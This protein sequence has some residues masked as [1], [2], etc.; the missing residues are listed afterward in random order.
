MRNRVAV[1]SLGILL[2]LSLA[3]CSGQ[4]SSITSESTAGP[5]KPL[6]PTPAL[7]ATH[8][9]SPLASPLDSPLPTPSGSRPFLGTRALEF[10]RDQMSFGPRPT[11]SDASRAT[12]DYIA[13]QLRESGWA[14][15]EEEFEYL[16]TPARNII[17]TLGV[18]PTIL[19]GAHYDTRRQADRDPDDPSQPVPGANDGASGVAV[20]LELARV[21]DVKATG[22]R[23][24]LAFFDAEDNG[25]LDGWDWIVGSRTMADRLTENPAAMVLVDMIGDADQRIY[26]E[27]NSDPD[28]RERLWDVAADLGYGEHFVN[29]VGYTLTDDHV[30]FLARGIPA[31][32]M[33]DFDYPYWHTGQDTLDKISADSLERVGRTLQVWL[34]RGAP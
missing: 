7:A 24:Q 10:A 3:A 26:W 21:L 25:G 18:G 33:I 5:A 9:P 6:A 12:G 16:D 30:P 31:I 13:Q 20:L 29:E 27:G 19:L 4:G 32:D 1:L 8:A 34:E 14:V 2:V 22:H 23:I 11:G 17:G 28:L 15:T